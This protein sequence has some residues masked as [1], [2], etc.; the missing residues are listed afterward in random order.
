LGAGSRTLISNGCI[1]GDKGVR[2][3]AIVLMA[4]LLAI[5]VMACTPAPKPQEFKSEVGR[6]SVMAPVALKERSQT[7][8]LTKFKIEAHFFEG[9]L[10]DIAYVVVYSDYPEEMVQ[11]SDPEKI[12]DGGRSGAVGSIN[13]KLV[14][15]TKITLEGN[16]GRELVVEAR[17]D[18]GAEW[19]SKARL[20]L[21]K[22]RMYVLDVTVKKGK[23]EVSVLDKFLQSFKLLGK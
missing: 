14:T 13:G 18:S 16:P 7:Y 2:K 9:N 8:D 23:F 4:L 19:T 3:P 11:K 12:L 1:E 17:D 5:W 15:E 21:V 10:G 6:F 22:N 20:F